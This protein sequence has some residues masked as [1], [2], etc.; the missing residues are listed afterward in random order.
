MPGCIGT[1]GGPVINTQGEVLGY[2]NQPIAGLYGA[3][4][5]I[6]SPAANAYWGGG[7]TIGSA[8]V[9]GY[10][11]GL[12]AAN[13]KADSATVEQRNKESMPVAAT[14]VPA[15]GETSEDGVFEA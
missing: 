8:L 15:A 10:Q 7:T 3:G 5:C 1:N 6:A 11:A 13:R 2:D 4:N 9:F 14:P 12:A